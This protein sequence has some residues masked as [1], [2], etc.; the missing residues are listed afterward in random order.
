MTGG[1][2]HAADAVAAVRRGEL[3][4]FPTDTVYGIGAAAADW[5][6][7][8]VAR[9]GRTRWPVTSKNSGVTRV[10]AAGGGDV[11]ADRPGALGRN[12]AGLD[13][14]LDIGDRGLGARWRGLAGPQHLEQFVAATRSLA[15]A[16]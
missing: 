6:P 11:L 5:K 3:I 7:P 4:V 15:Q 16:A 8:A 1:T 12:A 13:H 10:T 2:I 14:R 9:A